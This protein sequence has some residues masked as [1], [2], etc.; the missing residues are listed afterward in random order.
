MWPKGYLYFVNL[1]RRQSLLY[2]FILTLSPTLDCTFNCTHIENVSE[3]RV[4]SGG[5]RKD[6]L[7]MIFSGLC[8]YYFMEQYLIIYWF[9]LILRFGSKI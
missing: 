7:Y 1:C 9:K 2:H 5:V 4:S 6:V 3:I 8:A